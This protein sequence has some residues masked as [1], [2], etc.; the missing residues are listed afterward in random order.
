[1]PDVGKS[2]VL[3]IATS[4]STVTTMLLW[5]EAAVTTPPEKPSSTA[6][7]LIV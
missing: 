3:E 7:P 4:R 5:L 2:L 6:V 1:M